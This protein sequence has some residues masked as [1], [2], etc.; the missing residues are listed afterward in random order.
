MGIFTI[1]MIMTASMITGG[2]IN[3][4]VQ[5]KTFEVREYYQIEESVEMSRKE[6][7]IMRKDF[8]SSQ[9]EERKT[10]QKTEQKARIESYNNG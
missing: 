9:R 7:R 4:G 6:A 5:N 2:S 8:R 3:V 1:A 10:E